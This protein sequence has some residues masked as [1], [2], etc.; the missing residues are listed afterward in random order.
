MFLALRVLF[1]RISCQH[2]ANFLP[3]LITEIVSSFCAG[4]NLVF[5]HPVIVAASIY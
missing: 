2:L 3:V 1:C 4:Y 5:T